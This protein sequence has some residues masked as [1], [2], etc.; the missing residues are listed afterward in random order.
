[1]L[2]AYWLQQMCQTTT[3][4]H[5]STSE[6]VLKNKLEI[7]VKFLWTEPRRNA[8][9]LFIFGTGQLLVSLTSLNNS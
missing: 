9:V 1:M 7:R 8:F 5:F 3:F 2:I 6:C 4:L